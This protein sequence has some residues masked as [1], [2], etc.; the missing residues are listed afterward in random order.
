[1]RSNQLK[2]VFMKNSDHQALHQ[3]LNKEELPPNWPLSEQAVRLLIPQFLLEKL[4]VHPLTQGL[5]PIA[6]GKYLNAKSHQMSRSEH[7]NYLLLYCINGSGQVQINKQLFTIK[8]GDIVLFPKGVEHSYQADKLQPWSIYWV[9]FDGQLAGDFAERLLMKMPKGI[10]HVGQLAGI[11][12]QFE[13]IMALSGRGYTATN[14][15]HAVHV[16]QHMLSSLALQLRLSPSSEPDKLSIESIEA[17]MLENLDKDLTLEQ[18]AHYCQ[19][20]K[21]HFSKKFKALTDHS[22][23]QHFIHLKIENACFQLDRSSAT[24]KSIAESLG[25]NDPYYFSRLFKKIIGLSPAQYRQSK[26]R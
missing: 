17:Y 26:H 25:Y 14:V 13:Q 11:S 1:L 16:L 15:I 19:L 3:A 6:I 10:G 5:Y 20:S 2:I 22:P 21:Y 4:K 12:S 24:I 8:A 7:H 23:V 18:L 9:H